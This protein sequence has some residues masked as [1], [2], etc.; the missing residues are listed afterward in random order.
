MKKIILAT[1]AALVLVL[2]MTKMSYAMTT[3]DDESLSDVTGQAL[4]SLVKETDSTQGLDFFKLGLQAELSLNTNIKSLQLGCGGDNGAGGCDIDISNLSFGCVTG[5]GSPGS[6]ITLGSTQDT[7]A[8]QTALKD[9]VLTNPFFQFAIKGGSS[10]AT[11]QVVGVR[12]GAEKAEGPMSIGTLASYSGYLT[13]KTN[14]DI[15]A[16]KN[17]A[18]TCEKGTA[19][20][21]DADASKFSTG[22]TIE[23]LIGADKVYNKA[24]GFLGVKDEEILNILDLMKVRYKDLTIDT[25]AEH[26]DA[27]VK[28]TGTRLTQVKIANLGLGTTVDSVVSNLTVNQM[29]ATPLVG[30]GCDA[31][32]GADLSNLLMPVLV[33][34]IQKYMK[35]QTLI[36]LGIAVPAQ[37]SLSKEDYNALLTNTLNAYQL[38]YNLSNVHQ[39]DV[40]SNLFGI[41]LTSLSDGIKYPGYEEK[42]GRGWSMY[43][44]DAFTLNITDS[45]TNLMSNMVQNGQ[46]A[47]G[48][49]T[50]LAPA[51]RN[52]FGSLNFC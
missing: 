20:C 24:A 15:T 12:L 44:Q 45:L 27:D 19:N 14:L 39:L 40:N 38:P 22:F 46:A 41:A 23:K 36:G 18:V 52:C 1:I 21:S 5:P 26:S 34:G 30:S 16:Q 43:L 47:A 11:R 31:L 29:C 9:F 3:L 25:K 7:V 2:G 50:T 6:C 51:Y 32:V 8:N 48:N 42:V 33:S 49:I 28:A 10:A 37:G 35:Q 17:I 13:G 4:F